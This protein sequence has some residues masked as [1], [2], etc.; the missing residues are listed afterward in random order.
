MPLRCENFTELFD[1]GKLRTTEIA[2]I[3]KMSRATVSRYKN[4]P[5]RLL[6]SDQH[7]QAKMKNL[8]TLVDI[9]LQA[10]LLPLEIVGKKSRLASLRR[11]LLTASQSKANHRL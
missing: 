4:E 10:G 9:S 11:I 1:N 8:V 7:T 6:R 3:L 5:N 2:S